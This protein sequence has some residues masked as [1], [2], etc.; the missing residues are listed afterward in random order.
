ME[1]YSVSRC[2]F[3]LHRTTYR[4]DF[5]AMSDGNGNQARPFQFPGPPNVHPMTPE[6]AKHL[7]NAESTV[8]NAVASAPSSRSITDM[9]QQA[10]HC[11]VK[12]VHSLKPRAEL[13]L[14]PD[15]DFDNSGKKRL[16]AKTFLKVNQGLRLDVI[17]SDSVKGSRWKAMYFVCGTGQDESSQAI[18]IFSEM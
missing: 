2:H 15:Y 7:I 14:L 4:Q 11:I 12:F 1:F 10:P 8:L 16:H 3:H 9:S 6:S 5:L 13:D 17:K 18:E